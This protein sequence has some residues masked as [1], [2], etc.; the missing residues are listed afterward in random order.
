MNGVQTVLLVS[1]NQQMIESTLNTSIPSSNQ[2]IC[3]CFQLSIPDIGISIVNDRRKEELLYISLHRA[4]AIW[5]HIKKTEMKQFPN[6]T[7]RHL[8]ELYRL[9]QESLE[10]YPN[11][12]NII[13]TKYA[14]GNY[15]VYSFHNSPI[16]LLEK[17]FFLLVLNRKSLF[18]IIL[19]N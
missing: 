1:D 14:M 7:Q 6:D 16:N 11:D 8:E 2:S 12:Q 13:R 10:K 5:V 9:H 17:C 3:R 15:S 4:P 19:S 18:M